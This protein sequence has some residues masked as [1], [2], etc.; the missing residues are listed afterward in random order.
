MG[1]TEKR[2]NGK[3]KAESGKRQEARGKG[4][5]A[6]GKLAMGNMQLARKYRMFGDCLIGFAYCQLPIAYSLIYS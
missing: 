5:G 2:R 4:Q 1:E 6:R 3:R